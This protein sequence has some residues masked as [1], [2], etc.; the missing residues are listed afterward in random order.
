MQRRHELQ[1]WPWYLAN[2][3]NMT[4]QSIKQRSIGAKNK[5]NLKNLK[6]ICSEINLIVLVWL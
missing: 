6:F 2:F 1:R 5:I 4:Y 3:Y